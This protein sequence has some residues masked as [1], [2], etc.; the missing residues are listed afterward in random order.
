[1]YLL[2]ILE[3][4]KKINIINKDIKFLGLNYDNL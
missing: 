3:I 1:M 2:Y 4:H